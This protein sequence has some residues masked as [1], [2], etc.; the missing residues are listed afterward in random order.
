[1]DVNSYRAPYLYIYLTN[2]GT[3]VLMKCYSIRFRRV[4]LVIEML[5]QI[6]A[7]KYIRVG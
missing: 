4:W 6:E 2:P 3:N 5:E 1:M 7:P